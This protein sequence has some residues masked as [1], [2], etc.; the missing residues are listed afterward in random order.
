[1]KLT[2]SAGS[3]KTT[4][5]SVSSHCWIYSERIILLCCGI[6]SN[7]SSSKII[8]D[9]ASNT[10]T[11]GHSL[12]Y[13]YCHYGEDQRRDP[14]AILRSL[15]KQLCLQGPASKL[16]EPVLSIYHKRETAGDL[17]NL[18]SV[19]ESKCL[20]IELCAGFSHS[21]LI[22]DALDECDAKTRGRLFDVLQNVVSESKAARVKAFV[23][24]RDDADIRK[25]FSDSPNVY[26]QERD[27][28]G[29]INTYIRAELELC[30]V[31][32]SLLDGVVSSELKARIIHALETGASGMYTSCL[33]PPH[34]QDSTL[35][36]SVLKVYMGE[37]PNQQ[38]LQRDYRSR[39]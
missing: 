11:N 35:T 7:L 15:V 23:T 21:T 17:S 1:M 16:P 34:R 4:L 26:I 32:K 28:S 38:Y 30:I 8:D 6:Y 36:L 37:I 9:V 2:K 12:A 22:V 20:L 31:E 29:D 19:E 13:F 3:G 39:C 18:L 27:N 5:T 25:K 33:N 14:G 10:Q 24:S